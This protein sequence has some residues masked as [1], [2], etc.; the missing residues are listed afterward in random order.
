MKAN[1][2]YADPQW[3]R[4]LGAVAVALLVVAGVARAGG[5]LALAGEAQPVARVA[6]EIVCLAVSTLQ[7]AGSS[8]RLPQGH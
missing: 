3:A 2:W 5:P 4:A 6:G 7:G 8:A 1:A